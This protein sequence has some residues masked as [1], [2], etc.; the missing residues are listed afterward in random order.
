[1]DEEGKVV[2][3]REKKRISEYCTVG[4]Y[5]FKTAKLFKEMYTSLYIKDNYLEAGEQYIAP[6]YDYL[7]KIGGTIYIS[8][9]PAEKVHVLGTPEEVEKFIRTS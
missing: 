4:A 7:L 6:M 2:E 3:I 9:I 5:Y 1:M 8:D